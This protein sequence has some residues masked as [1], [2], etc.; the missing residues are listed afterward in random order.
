M[1]ALS[2]R[3]KDVIKENKIV[4]EIKS[5]DYIE[6]NLYG[7]QYFESPL[8]NQFLKNN[9]FANSLVLNINALSQVSLMDKIYVE[10]P[11]MQAENESNETMSGFYL[12]AGV[13]HEV[14]NGGIYKKKV[15]LGRNGMEKSPDVKMEY[16]VETL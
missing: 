16:G 14:S 12:V 4:Q 9:F 6:P 8:R 13:Q 10:I 11:S 2:F 1:T 5:M 3:N 7:E 15:A